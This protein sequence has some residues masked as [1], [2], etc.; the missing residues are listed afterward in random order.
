M[1]INLEGKPFIGISLPG[2]FVFRGSF[3]FMLEHK[4]WPVP[5]AKDIKE[6]ELEKIRE[7]PLFHSLYDTNNKSLFPIEDL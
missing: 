5:S 1:P 2:D 7:S 3:S 6:N 4:Q